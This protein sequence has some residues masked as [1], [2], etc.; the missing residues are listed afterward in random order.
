MNALPPRWGAA[1]RFFITTRRIRL[2]GKYTMKHLGLTLACVAALSVASQQSQAGV[3]YKED[4]E[5]GTAPGWYLF[6]TDNFWHV[7]ENAPASGRFAL[8]YVENET[9]GPTPN[10]DYA[11][12]PDSLGARN[13]GEAVSPTILLPSGHVA[14]YFDFLAVINDDPVAWDRLILNGT[15]GDVDEFGVHS[16]GESLASTSP[17]D[18][19]KV[20]LPVNSGYHRIGID[21]SASAGHLFALLFVFDTFD[22]YANHGAGIRIDNIEIDTGPVI[23]EPSTFVLSSIAFGACWAFRRLKRIRTAA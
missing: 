8:G 14:L 4:F 11:S 23:P 17:G 13:S 16:I 10:G 1:G 22:G 18:G 12:G 20:A 7:T 21:I 9:P 19:G 15:F 5:S 2:S 3:I 6:S